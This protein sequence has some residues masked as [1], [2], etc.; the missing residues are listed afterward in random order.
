LL[1]LCAPLAH[2]QIAADV[3][4]GFGTAHA[5]ANSGGIDNANSVNAF[6]PCTPGTGDTDCQTLPKLGGLFMGFSG[7]LM[8][9]KRYGFGGD[10]SFQPSRSDYGPLQSRQVFYDF[11]G[12][13]APLSEKRFVVQLKGGIGGARTSFIIPSS[14]CVGTAVCS[15]QNVPVGNSNHFQVN[16]GVDVQLYVT[17]HVFIRPEFDYHYVVGLTDQFGTKSVV[18]GMV[19][20]GYSFGSRD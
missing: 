15:T 1:A 8:L 9:T 17:S 16:A 12:I 18:Q 11:D 7:D 13:Y 10:V 20:V 6:G 3:A 5:S 14:E 4:V 2:A 19:S